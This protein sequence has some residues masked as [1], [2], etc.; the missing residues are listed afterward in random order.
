MKK[1]HSKLPEQLRGKPGFHLDKAAE[2]KFSC[3]G[4][5]RCPKILHQ[6]LLAAHVQAG[7][8]LH[9]PSAPFFHAL[10]TILDSLRGWDGGRLVGVF[11]G[12]VQGQIGQG[13]GAA[14]GSGRW[15]RSGTR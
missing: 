8:C 3:F 4:W 5:E 10:A 14:W 1:R 7:W 12:I 2:G 13:F 9:C 6:P 11:P 15:G